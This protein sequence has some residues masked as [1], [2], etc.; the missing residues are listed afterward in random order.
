MRR[1]EIEK[2]HLLRGYRVNIDAEIDSEYARFHNKLTDILNRY[3]PLRE[4]QMS[5][6]GLDMSWIDKR[7][8]KLINSKHKL[9]TQLKRGNVT[10]GYFR[11]FSDL[12]SHVIRIRKQNYY[13]NKFV[14]C[15]DD[16]SKLWST[17]NRVFGR[18]TGMLLKISKNELCQME[19][20]I[21]D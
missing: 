2:L 6:K 12:L 9:F 10:Y 4:K 20:S 1:F 15:E 16:S 8:R 7:I 13:S 19:K 11:A 3:F 21:S 18:K 14:K 5:L 17:R